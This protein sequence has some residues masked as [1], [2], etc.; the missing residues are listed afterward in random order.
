MTVFPQT[1]DGGLACY[2]QL[3]FFLVLPPSCVSPFIIQLFL[4]LVFFQVVF[5]LL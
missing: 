1:I 5:L 4:C 3:L 2:I